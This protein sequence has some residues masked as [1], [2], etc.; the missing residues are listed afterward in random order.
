MNFAPSLPKDDVLLYLKTFKWDFWLGAFVPIVKPIKLQYFREKEK[1]NNVVLSANMIDRQLSIIVSLLT[2]KHL[3]RD[4]LL[5]DGLFPRS[6]L[7][8][9]QKKYTRM[10]SGGSCRAGLCSGHHTLSLFYGLSDCLKP[11][12]QNSKYIFILKSL[13]GPII[14]LRVFPVH[15]EIGGFVFT[16]YKEQRCND[17][18]ML[19][20][21]LLGWG[22][23]WQSIHFP[24]ALIPGADPPM[25]AA[26]AT[27]GFAQNNSQLCGCPSF[28]LPNSAASPALF[29]PPQNFHPWNNSIPTAP[30]CK[31]LLSQ[32]SCPGPR[33]GSCSCQIL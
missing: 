10:L 27:L 2:G 8:L 28:H 9:P 32:G 30:C 15:G 3:K 25:P 26:P 1:R 5:K 21:V 19:S 33:F 11:C 14:S 29:L 6:V 31:V 16:I 12:Y 23:S 20:R 4:R 13:I 17:A 22:C 7:F 18:K 24:F